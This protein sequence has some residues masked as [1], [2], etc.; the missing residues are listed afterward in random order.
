MGN[1]F[2]SSSIVLAGVLFSSIML[3]Q[4]RGPGIMA[5][6]PANDNKQFDKHDLSGI[7]T[8]NGTP[9]GY[10]GGG[11]CRD[12]GDRGYSNDVPPMTALGQKMYEANK[13]SYGRNKEAPKRM[14][15]PKK[16]SAGAALSRLPMARILIRL[17]IRKA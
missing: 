7:W 15:I 17:A 13:P 12:C 8:R 16:R 1:R 4:G 3:A 2:V 10:G 14:R 11:V 5:H 6:N 9:G